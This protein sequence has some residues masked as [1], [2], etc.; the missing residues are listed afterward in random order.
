[1][2][3]EQR[4]R[5]QRTQFRERVEAARESARVFLPAW[6][7]HARAEDKVVAIIVSRLDSLVWKTSPYDHAARLSTSRVHDPIA[8]ESQFV[9]LLKSTGMPPAAQH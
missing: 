2:R 5:R 8:M 3:A 7:C 6:R 1:M 4:K 9:Q